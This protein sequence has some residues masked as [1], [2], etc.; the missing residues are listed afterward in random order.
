M[1]KFHVPNS[2]NKEMVDNGIFI[3]PHYVFFIG[4][5][6]LETLVICAG[7]AKPGW[8]Q[9]FMYLNPETKFG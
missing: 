5:V 7:L 2:R 3:L 9:N 4:M 1:T 6:G 8:K